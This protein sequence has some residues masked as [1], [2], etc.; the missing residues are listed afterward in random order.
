MDMI[1]IWLALMALFFILPSLLYL[2]DPAA[3]FAAN[4]QA[5]VATAARTDVRVMYGTF[6]IAIG[7]FLI[8]AVFGRGEPRTALWLC[9]V[10]MALIVL[11]RLIGLV[12][13]HGDQSF[14]RFCLL[15]EVPVTLVCGLLLF[16]RQPAPFHK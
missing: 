8:P 16:I 15:F 3:G 4:G 11:G 9:F 10:V 1:R 2:G 5:L 12:V 6:P 14:T 7:L 13:D